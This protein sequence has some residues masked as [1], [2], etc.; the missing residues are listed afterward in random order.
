MNHTTNQATNQAA[1]SAADPFI[2]RVE[3]QLVEL[4]DNDL[5]PSDA[6][7]GELGAGARH[8]ALAPGAK[9]ARPRLVWLFG[10]AVGADAAGL[11]D[12]AIAAELIHTASLLHDD[13]VDNS[14]FR[15]GRTT[16]NARWGNTA[17]ILT[18]DLVLSTAIRQLAGHPPAITVAAVQAVADMSRAALI[19][20]RARDRVDVDE[21]TWLQIARGKTGALFGWCGRSAGLLAG[22]EDAAGRFEDCG[23]RF[24]VAFQLADDL[25][26]FVRSGTGKPCLADIRTGGPSR[27]LIVA[28]EADPSVAAALASLWSQSD[29][30]EADVDACA[31]A[32]QNTD[33]IERC[34]AMLVDE[35]SAAIDA[36]GPWRDRPAGAR[37][38]RWARGL[39]DK[40][41]QGA[42]T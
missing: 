34:E 4:L 8:L 31:R 21:A 6:P 18:G 13:V 29:R 35:V 24:G 1:L 26:D 22:D 41:L 40:Y 30:S 11:C 10:E 42:T 28:A 3:Q 23:R 5:P 27:V 20:V 7:D 37:L 38:A 16:A 39:A 2:E 12:L 19:E 32:V 33:A 36:L 15:R 17:A 9:R 25:K 14:G